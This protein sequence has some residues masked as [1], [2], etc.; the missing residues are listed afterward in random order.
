MPQVIETLAPGV[1]HRLLLP[2]LACP[3]KLPTIRAIL[4]KTRYMGLSP[5]IWRRSSQGNASRIATF[6]VSSRRSFESS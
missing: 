3:P 4:R 6:P 1:R 5:D 2:M